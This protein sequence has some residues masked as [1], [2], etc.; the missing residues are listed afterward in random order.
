[1]SEPAPFHQLRPR[2]LIR[3]QVFERLADDIITG[4]LA[5]KEEIRDADLQAEYGVSRTP[6]REAILQLADL[7]L[8]ELRSNRYTRVA[9]VDYRRHLDHWEAAWSLVAYSSERITHAIPASELATLRGHADRL[10]ALE[11]VGATGLEE[12]RL[13]YNFHE[14]VVHLAGNNVAD[15][16]FRDR[17]RLHILRPVA[18]ARS[19]PE[20]S[21]RLVRYVRG[22]MAVLERGEGA[23][24][25]DLVA[26]GF[27]LLVAPLRE[28]VVSGGGRPATCTR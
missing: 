4:R 20:T 12:L 21:D 17:L 19:G 28:L 3:H 14:E 2:T 24:A 15:A 25:R 23:V 8:I 7:G 9:P 11:T 10:I 6:I 22:L 26:Q 1:M 18:D 5:T 13:W 27:N 16:L